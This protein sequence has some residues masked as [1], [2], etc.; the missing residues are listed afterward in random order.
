MLSYATSKRAAPHVAASVDK[1]MID[2]LYDLI[3]GRHT[4][5]K[6]TDLFYK[7]VLADPTL[8]P[9]F[10]RTDI[11][12]LRSHQSMFISMLVG[13]RVVY[14]GKEISAA[15]AGAR[16]R[17]LGNAIFD[18]FVAHFREALLEVGVDSAKADKVIGLLEQKRDLV[19]RGAT[20]SGGTTQPTA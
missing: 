9:F 14:T 1:N 15:H 3:G 5:A 8:Q 18:N 13:G 16:A 11:K 10:D 2:E 20:Q 4:V 12:Q 19:L 17:G 7:K 6:A